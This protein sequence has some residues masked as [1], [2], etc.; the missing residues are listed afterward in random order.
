MTA[1]FPPPPP[2]ARG[3]GAEARER[4]LRAALRLFAEKGFARTSTREIAQAAGA[5]VAAI[6]Y[7][8]GDKA[9]LYGATFAESAGGDAGE[10]I[11]RYDDPALPLEASMRIF[12]AGYAEP[13]KQGEAVRHTIRLH[14]REMVEP[15]RQWMTQLERDIQRPHEALVRV[16]CRHLGLAAPDDDIHRLALSVAGMAMQL[17]VM[18]DV[19]DVLKPSLLGDA[20]AIDTW[21]DRLARYAVALVAAEAERR[22]TLQPSSSAGRRTVTAAGRM[23]TSSRTPRP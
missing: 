15:T 2:P 17:Y 12:M 1:S 10:L 21:A 14:L 16:L 13:L 7:Y 19:I 20:T 23:A 22:N 4:L 11:A 6:S 3:N 5:N 8:F 9:G 18:Q